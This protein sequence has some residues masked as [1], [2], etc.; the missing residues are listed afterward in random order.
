MGSYLP[1]LWG[2]TLAQYQVVDLQA[3]DEAQRSMRAS[4]FGGGGAIRRSVF[5][6]R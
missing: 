4:G 2:E 6:S 3:L 5:V 1:L